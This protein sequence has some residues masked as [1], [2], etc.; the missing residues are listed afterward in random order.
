MDR[1]F[2]GAAKRLDDIDLPRIGARIGVG[3]DEIHAFMDVEAAG[4]GFDGLGRPK[5]LFEPH[6]FYRN[7]SGAKRDRAVKEGLA[8]PKWG[9]KPYPMDSYPRLIRAMD[10]DPTAA[11]NSAS[12]GL[13]Q[14]LGSNH[15][16]VGYATPQ[17]MV[18]A[19]MEDEE[20]QLEAIVQ[21]LIA[22]EIADDLKAHRWDVVARVYNGPGYR[23]HDY[24]GRMA[25]AYAK[26]RK[27]KDTPY[28][29]SCTPQA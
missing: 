13:G 22:N 29:P 19:F 20:A 2:K 21:F 9:T 16:L 25:Q 5:M 26:W 18:A 1:S 4:K 23:K 12:W 7:L 8:Y 11:L 14:V 28:P 6:L 24:D 10:I 3:E 15:K 17:K 27:I